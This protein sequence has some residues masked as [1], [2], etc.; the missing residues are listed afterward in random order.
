[1]LHELI[2]IGLE[3]FTFDLLYHLLL[4]NLLLKHSFVEHS[5]FIP[6]DFHHKNAI[7]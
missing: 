5:L 1:M 2:I 6:F 4:K 7:K 3:L